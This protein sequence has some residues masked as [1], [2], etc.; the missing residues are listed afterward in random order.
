MSRKSAYI[1]LH[2][3][4]IN[5]SIIQTLLKYFPA[6]EVVVIDV[7]EHIRKKK[8]TV[9]VN[10][11]FILKEYG[12]G[13]LLGRRKPRECFWRTTYIFRSIKALASKLL[14]PDEYEFSFQNTSLFD[15][16]KK[17]LPHYVFTDHTHLTN[18]RYPEFD[19]NN[20]Y[21]QRWIELEKEI[22]RNATINFTRSQYATDSIIYDYGCDPEKI[23][24]VYAG[25]NVSLN[26]KVNDKKYENKNI[27]I[28]F[29]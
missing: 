12:L 14:S 11:F 22:Y 9:I 18:L 3:H 24:C 10:I 15:G 13:I 1:K 6:M 27:S 7:G 20:L 23:L 4:Q 29:F 5:D 28:I 21:S 17:G 19:R 26:F 25:S 2:S 16:S 8:T